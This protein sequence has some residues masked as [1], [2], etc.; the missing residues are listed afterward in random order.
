[1]HLIAEPILPVAAAL[2]EGAIWNFRDNVLHWV[3][4]DNFQ[5]H[6]YDPATGEDRFIEVGQHV[7]TVVRKAPEL[8]G[9]FVVGLVDEIAHVT[10]DGKL[11]KLAKLAHNKRSRCNDGKCDPAGRFWC[12]SFNFDEK[13]SVC[14]LWMMDLEG[15]VHQKLDGVGV[16]NGLV[17]TSDSKNMYYVDSLSGHLALFDYDI[18][19]GAIKN[20]RVAVEN[21]WGGYFDGMTIDSDDNVYIAVWEG[22]VVLRINP[23]SGKLLDRIEIPGA[24]NITSCAFG[25]PNL[26]TLFITSSGKETDPKDQP[27]AGHLFKVEVP[28]AQGRRAFEYKGV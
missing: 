8:G 11:T 21:S 5:V 14:Q 23:R 27:N 16:S 20:R 28:G 7:S 9:G 18:E 6:T 22:G 13:Q 12:G 3:D 2:G 19:S 10:D 15:K 1:M 25:G 24:M 17:W 26:T 4:I